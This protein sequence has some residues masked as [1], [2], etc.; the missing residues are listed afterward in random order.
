MEFWN[1]D[2]K[3]IERC[4]IKRGD[5]WVSG[6]AMLKFFPP[7]TTNIVGDNNVSNSHLDTVL[8]GRCHSVVDIDVPE[9]RH[10]IKIN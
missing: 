6:E 8:E 10:Q 3:G 5:R 7:L 2:T 4:E 9:G 1:S